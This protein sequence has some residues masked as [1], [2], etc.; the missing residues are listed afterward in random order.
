MAKFER[1]AKTFDN[2]FTFQRSHSALYWDQH[3]RLLEAGVNEPRYSIEAGIIIEPSRT[4]LLPASEDLGDASWGLFSG[5]S[6]A[7]VDGPG[8][9]VKGFRL[10]DNNTTGTA[11]LTESFSIGF[12]VRP[13]RGSCLFKK[14]DGATIYPSL[15]LTST[16]GTAVSQNVVINTNTGQIITGAADVVDRGE[17]WEVTVTI[18]TLLNNNTLRYEIRPAQSDGSINS[19]MFTGECTVAAMQVEQSSR[20]TSYIPTTGAAQARPSEYLRADGSANWTGFGSLAFVAEI[21]DIK[22]PNDVAETWELIALG[23]DMSNVMGFKWN[24]AADEITAYL[25]FNGTTTN[26]TIPTGDNVRLAMSWDEEA[27]EIRA[28]V[29]GQYVSASHTGADFT[30][31]EVR[32]GSIPDDGAESLNICPMTVNTFEV[33]N[34]ALDAADVTRVSLPV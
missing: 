9:T 34:H 5:L 18:T 4:N 27:Q 22:N 3:G 31:T 1:V 32:F 10:L 24:G 29:N 13:F 30:F 33:F 7:E 8:P 23:D 25:K 26:L 12:G 11:Y 16:G 19:V 17:W 21:V 28:A 2:M 6:Y 15:S 20:T 14:T